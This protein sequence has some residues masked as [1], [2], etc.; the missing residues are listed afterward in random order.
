MESHSQK[1]LAEA[2]KLPV[3]DRV[4]IANQLYESAER[5]DPEMEQ[6]WS[7]EIADRLREIDEGK[8]ELLDGDTVMREMQDI[9][10]GRKR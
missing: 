6:A 10:D 9:I 7:A 2:L 4:L 3:E 8:V 5:I 1:I